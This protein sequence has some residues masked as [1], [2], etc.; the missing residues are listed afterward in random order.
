M[1]ITMKIHTKN[2]E[3]SINFSEDTRSCQI[4]LREVET[5]SDPNET[6]L[7]PA[8]AFLSFNATI[9]EAKNFNLGDDCHITIAPASS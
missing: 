1:Q 5:E 4:M 2:T 8:P 3:E 9:A 7:R 6:M